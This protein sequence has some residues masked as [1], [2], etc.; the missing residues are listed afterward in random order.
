MA[1]ISEKE[2]AHILQNSLDLVLVLDPSDR[3]LMFINANGAD[4]LG[5]SVEEL[6]S[7]GPFTFFPELTDA[8]LEGILENLQTLEQGEGLTLVTPVRRSLGTDHDFEFRMQLLSLEGRSY[9]IA[10]GRDVAERVA[11]T[12][13]MHTL[14]ADAQ[15]ESRQDKTTHLLQRDAFLQ[16]FREFLNQLDPNGFRLTLLVIDLKN[17]SEINEQF[18][19]S[20]GDGV[21]KNMGKLLHHYAG[22]DDVC[23][24][25]SGRKLCILLPNKGQHDGLQMAD[26]ISA[27]LGKVKY[28]EFPT[29]RIHSSVSVSE[30]P[31]PGEPELLLDKII[32]RMRELRNPEVAHEIHRFGL[33]SLQLP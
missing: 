26:K 15:I 3:S 9:V 12:D 2:I 19:Q 21:L 8:E 22:K 25:F 5:H 31:E 20:I 27:A 14:L 29:L 6:L 16:A 24:R 7:S 28:S 10:N 1:K 17:L 4:W 32:T 11:A 33:V 30:L 18:G 13:Q 23:A